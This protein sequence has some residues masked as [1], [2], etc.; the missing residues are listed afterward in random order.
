MW[1]RKR[2]GHMTIWRPTVTLGGV[3]SDQLRE[4]AYAYK[5]SKH[6]LYAVY[7]SGLTIRTCVASGARGTASSKSPEVD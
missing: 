6:P 3:I 5:E 4:A 7:P 2:A 1:G